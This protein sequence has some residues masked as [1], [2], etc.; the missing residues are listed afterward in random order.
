MMLLLFACSPTESADSPADSGPPDSSPDTG[1]C[2]V[3]PDEPAACADAVMGDYLSL[4]L[5]D[6][7]QDEDVLGQFTRFDDGSVEFTTDGGV[8]W[9]LSNGA[10]E[11]VWAELP[12]L[13]A[14]GTVRLTIVGDCGS[15]GEGNSIL[16]VEDLD[17]ALL[18]LSAR[19]GGP[20]SLE[21]W[22]ATMTP[23]GCGEQE[24][25]DECAECQAPAAVA[26]SGPAA[27][28]AWQ[29]G[30]A[31]DGGLRLSVGRASDGSHYRCADGIGEDFAA[32]FV[33]PE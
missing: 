26:V 30:E 24:M 1:A 29:G 11:G 21:D 15:Y 19:G 10:T 18:L 16:R 22:S 32:W 17:G 33:V 23:T 9:E 14:A 6:W 8:V 3:I 31:R 25:P 28:E 27:L 5:W 13:A 2:T 4:C 20:W 7:P 12:D